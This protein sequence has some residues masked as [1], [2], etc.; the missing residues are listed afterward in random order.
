MWICFSEFL[1]FT[2]LQYFVGIMVR[3]IFSITFSGVRVD[4]S[5]EVALKTVRKWLADNLSCVRNI[6]Y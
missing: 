3:I 6:L 2:F 5:A 1:I 4:V